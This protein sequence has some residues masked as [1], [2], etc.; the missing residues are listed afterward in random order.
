LHQREKSDTL[1]NYNHNNVFMSSP[2]KR[3]LTDIILLIASLIGAII[4]IADFFLDRLPKIGVI[5]IIVILSLIWIYLILQRTILKKDPESYKNVIQTISKISIY[6]LPII[7]VSILGTLYFV[8]KSKCNEY[9][10]NS[11]TIGIAYFNS[12]G[13]FQAFSTELKAI[14]DDKIG[15]NSEIRVASI[16][17]YFDLNSEKK[18]I[19]SLLIKESEKNCIDRG[20]MTYGYRE[21]SEELFNCHLF[22]KESDTDKKMEG[23]PQKVLDSLGYKIKLPQELAFKIP[24]YVDK[25]SEIILGI[26]NF[27]EGSLIEAKQR[28]EEQL[29]ISQSQSPTKSIFRLASYN[30]NEDG[31]RDKTDYQ[32]VIL[33]YLATLDIISGNLEEAKNLYS[34]VYL[35]DASSIHSDDNLVGI[36]YQNYMELD[37]LPEEIVEVV[38]EVDEIPPSDEIVEI[39]TTPIVP[40]EEIEAIATPVTESSVAPITPPIVSTYVDR[41]LI[42][43]FKVHTEFVSSVAF[44]PDGKSILTGS[45]DYTACLWSLNGK[46]LQG[47]KGHSYE[48]LSVTFS[49]D[50]STI[51]TGSRDRTARLWDL[52]GNM[53][54]EFNGHSGWIHSVAFSPDGKSILTGSVDKTARMWDLE[55]NVIQEFKGH[56]KWINSVA[57]S[58]DGKT[59]LTG[60][61]DDTARLWDLKGNTIQEF[62]GHSK[63]IHSVAFSPDGKT[64]LTGSADRT[65]RLWDLE[66]NTIQEFIG[67]SGIVY[68][69]AF[70]PDGKTILTGSWDKTARLWDLEG[71]TIQEFTGH[72]NV[73][74]SVVFSSDGQY[75]LTGSADMTVRRY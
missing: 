28:F 20:I 45:A 1:E 14:L 16:P 29:V 57:F 50:N 51:L 26:A 13:N 70:S 66:G 53:I 60:A 8:K 37:G 63:R 62:I 54:Q 32:S 24:D 59:I 72:S 55:G 48:V 19:L 52:E 61:M 10:S 47:F 33:F 74:L 12:T 46:A 75:L 73:I 30:R 22:V 42:K 36:A 15:V 43:E 4:T 39:E 44:S 65:A 31:N 25:I 6:I 9:E 68:S 67:H 64:I 56:T 23:H 71:N 2:T 17:H 35:T 18:D 3:N 69:I 5:S 38:N 58:P 49:P 11:L 27:H 41:Q 21:K 7:I 40:Q 34:Q